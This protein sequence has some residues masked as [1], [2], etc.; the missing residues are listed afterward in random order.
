VP[1]ELWTQGIRVLARELRA[2]TFS[3]TELTGAYLKRISAVN[4]SLNAIVT[5]DHEAGVRS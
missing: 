4:P 1:A 2:G 3:A 5:L